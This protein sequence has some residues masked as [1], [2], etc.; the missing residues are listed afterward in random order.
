MPWLISEVPASDA[1]HASPRLPASGPAAGLP[2]SPTPIHNMIDG[3]LNP[4][5]SARYSGWN[6]VLESTGSGS[7]QLPAEP[8]K[9]RLRPASLA[10]DPKAFGA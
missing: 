5:L 9:L 2:L 8:T 4:A 1:S 3:Q 7:S 10:Y 6:S